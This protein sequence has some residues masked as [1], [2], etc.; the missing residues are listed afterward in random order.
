MA[1]LKVQFLGVE[2]QAQSAQLQGSCVTDLILR[3]QLKCCH[4]AIL[5]VL[6][7]C[8]RPLLGGL[9]CCCTDPAAMGP[10]LYCQQ[11][12]KSAFLSSYIK[13]C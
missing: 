2:P 6:G 5:S 12:Q 13:Y 10:V 8:F 11:A 9:W 1:C 7:K 4:I 3:S